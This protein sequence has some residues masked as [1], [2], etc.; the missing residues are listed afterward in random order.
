MDLRR[1]IQ[2]VLRC[3]LCENP[4]FTMFCDICHIELCKVCVGEHLSDESKGHKVV[5]FRN[6]GST[7]KCPKNSTKICE[8]HCEECEIPICAT[9]VSCGEHEQH[10]KVD[11]IKTFE[12]KKK[13]C[14]RGIYKN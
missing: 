2:D 13:T 10:K 14:Y 4:S 3:N 12:N 11:L 5:Q 7:P 9:C 1:D 6:R 8:L